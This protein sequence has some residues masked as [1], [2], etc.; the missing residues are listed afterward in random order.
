MFFS[1]GIRYFIF[2]SW[3]GEKSSLQFRCFCV[4]VRNKVRTE[5]VDFMLV[6]A[7]AKINLSLDI[8]GKREDGYHLLEMIM[9]SIDL[10]DD[11]T[12]EETEEGI[13]LTCDKKYI[14]ADSRNIAYKA[15]ELIKE[16]Y[17]ITKGVSIRINKNIP[18]S[19]GLAGG[20]T[21]AAAVLKGMNELFNLKIGQKELMAI[22]L[23]LGA[24]VP[25]C[26]TGG[27]CL[28]KGIGEVIEV[29]EPFQGHIILL[30]K[31]PFGISTK[32][33]YGSFR[34][35]KIKKHVETE[36]LISAMKRSDLTLMNY[37]MRNLLENVILAKHPMLK[38]IKQ[39]LIRLGAKTSLMSGSGPT[40]YGIFDDMEKARKAESFL[41][42][43]G[44][45]VILTKTI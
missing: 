41:S 38:N 24:D 35:D 14:P 4:I 27:T 13:L 22:G 43:G 15:A 28:C 9:Q 8:V 40:I 39:T 18:V 2:L 26:L 29:L 30:V 1:T 3:K 17:G 31:P 34:L 36:K 37:H 5:G 32:E 16:T 33:A 20:S 7:N 12:L 45:E 6:R 44:N 10:H 25:F 11:V 21:D 23:R 19:A 42:K